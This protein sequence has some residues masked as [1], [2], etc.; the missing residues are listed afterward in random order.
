MNSFQD[1]EKSLTLILVSS[2]F[3]CI[4]W[5]KAGVHEYSFTVQ[6]SIYYS[7]VCPLVPLL[8]RFMIYIKNRKGGI[9][10]HGHTVHVLFHDHQKVLS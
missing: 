6:M 7:A 8:I 1:L 3:T 9:Q 2:V 4:Q 5:S 10:V